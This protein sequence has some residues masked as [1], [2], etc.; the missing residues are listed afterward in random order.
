MLRILPK[1]QSRSNS[2]WRNIAEPS[3]TGQVLG[4]AIGCEHF[5]AALIAYLF[6]CC[7]PSQVSGLIVPVV[8]DSVDGVAQ[9]S[10]PN[11]GEDVISESDKGFYPWLMH[12]YAS[13]SIMLVKFKVFLENSTLYAA[14]C[15][16]YRCLVAS[17]RG[18]KLPL[19]HLKASAR[20]NVSRFKMRSASIL[21]C[22]A[23]ASA[24]PIYCLAPFLR[25]ADDGHSAILF[26]SQVDKP[27]AS[28]FH[29]V[30]IPTNRR[31]GV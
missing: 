27:V 4:L 10:I 11:T 23:I 28:F 22:T 2:R 8:I 1:P 15:G 9:W 31:L 16:I 14:P 21:F 6:A 12:G 29:T 5:C 26:P 19:F 17:M 3:P 13:A 24:S 7:R 18:I 20:L 25:L 30:N